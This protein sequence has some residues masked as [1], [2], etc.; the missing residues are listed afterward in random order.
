MVHTFSGAPAY[1]ACAISRSR[2]SRGSNFPAARRKSSSF[3]VSLHLR[4]GTASASACSSAE[5]DAQ[6]GGALETHRPGAHKAADGRPPL[7]ALDLGASPRRP[8]SPAR[9]FAR[10]SFASFASSSCD[11]ADSSLQRCL[12]SISASTR[13]A[14]V[15]CSSSGRQ[16]AKARRFGE[17]FLE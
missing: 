15:F 3:P 2:R 17:C 5:S 7:C 14:S 10:V 8:V 1:E 13:L 16:N 9:C 11:A 12:G 6:R 4:F